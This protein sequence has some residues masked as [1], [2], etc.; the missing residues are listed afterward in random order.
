MLSIRETDGKDLEF[1][2]L[3]KLLDEHID[4]RNGRELQA[5]RYDKYNQTDEIAHAYVIYLDGK[6]VGCGAYKYYNSTCAELKRIFVKEEYRRKKIASTLIGRIELDA[7]DAGYTYMILE[8]ATSLVEAHQLYYKLGY[9]LIDNFEP[10]TNME[11]SLCMR[12]KL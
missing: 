12:K 3:C 9:Q 6:S 5:E 11:T 10:F 1:K 4:S 7:Y 8:S 2:A